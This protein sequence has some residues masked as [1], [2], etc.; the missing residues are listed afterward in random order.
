MKYLFIVIITALSLT[1]CGLINQE[2]NVTKNPINETIGSWVITNTGW[3][4]WVIKKEENKE[5]RELIS[6]LE[7]A[8]SANTFIKEYT[9]IQE[10]FWKYLKDNPTKG[11]VLEHANIDRIVPYIHICKSTVSGDDALVRTALKEY[12]WV[13]PPI[14]TGW[15][16]II[17]SFFEGRAGLK[18]T[19]EQILLSQDSLPGYFNQ[20]ILSR[21]EKLWSSS[22]DT[23]MEDIK[24][25]E[26]EFFSREVNEN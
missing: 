1:S 13:I 10:E 3:T 23:C 22:E 19:Y 12:V 20:L 11:N 25:Y 2:E 8:E 18:E 16:T 15:T 17:D 6:W 21:K 5:F 24:K 9:K 4:W 14:W 26:K 7:K